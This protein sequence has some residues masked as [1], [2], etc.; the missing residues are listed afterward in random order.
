MPLFALQIESQI[1]SAYSHKVTLP[2]GIVIDHAKRWFRSTSTRHARRGG[3][4]ET[5]ALNTNPRRPTKCATGRLRDVGRLIVIDFIDM[6]A[7]EPARRGSP[8]RRGQAGPCTDPDRPV[9]VRPAGFRQRLRPSIRES[10][11]IV[12]PRCTG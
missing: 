11:N 5:T 4:I 8:A 1:E 12:C 9:R 7:E 6:G 2:C 10:T 3:D